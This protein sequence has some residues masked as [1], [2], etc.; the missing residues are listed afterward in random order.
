MAFTKIA[1]DNN[2]EMIELLERAG[3]D[4]VQDISYPNDE[5]PSCLVVIDGAEYTVFA[6]DEE[7][8]DT[9]QVMDA[10]EIM[11]EFDDPRDVV[12]FLKKL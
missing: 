4:E 10:W 11:D 2:D 7:E 12:D 8:W 3:F 1:Y 5:V 6:P 9:Y